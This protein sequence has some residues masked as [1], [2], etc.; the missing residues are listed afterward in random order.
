M[1]SQTECAINF[2][3]GFG[4]PPAEYAAGA[5]VGSPTR[6]YIYSG[7]QLLATIEGSATK[8]HHSDHLSLRVTTD[9]N[10]V[11]IADSGHYPY[12]ENSY[13]TGGANKL[14]FTSYA[15][16]NGTGESGNDYAIFRYNVNRLGRFSSPDPI[17]GRIGDPQSLNRYVYVRN[18]PV[19]LIDLLGLDDDCSWDP[20]TST[21]RCPVSPEPTSPI[22]T[23]GSW[24]GDILLGSGGIFG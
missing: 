12:G 16:D 18:D 14:K 4:T 3:T 11:K 2:S 22:P 8:Y 24:R 5:G 23:G 9:T 20:G 21:L 13:E 10:G 17:T 1:T 6:E 15:R 19:N 7:S